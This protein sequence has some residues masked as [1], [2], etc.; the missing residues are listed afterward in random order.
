MDTSEYGKRGYGQ[1]QYGRYPPTPEEQDA[2]TIVGSVEALKVEAS[3]P[4]LSHRVSTSPD[5]NI[6]ISGL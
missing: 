4:P 6:L 5:R 3:L 1:S 2:T